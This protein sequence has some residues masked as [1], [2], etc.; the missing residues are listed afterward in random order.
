M[1]RDL[2]L[3]WLY[4]PDTLDTIEPSQWADLHR[5]SRFSDTPEGGLLLAIFAQ[6]LDDYRH[7][8]VL[9][10]RSAK[11]WFERRDECFEY[12]CELLG[13]DADRVRKAV[14]R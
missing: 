7:G 2:I 6:A 13:V 9:Q 11:N 5:M 12:I 8:T 10:Q 3:D 1:K 14:L 4:L